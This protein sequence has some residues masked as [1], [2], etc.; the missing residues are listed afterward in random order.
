MADL[1]DAARPPRRVEHDGYLVMFAPDSSLEGLESLHFTVKRTYLELER[2]G[3]IVTQ[4]GR[5]SWVAEQQDARL[6]AAVVR[7]DLVGVF[8][9]RVGHHDLLEQTPEDLPHPVRS[10]LGIEGAPA[11]ELRQQVQ[12]TILFQC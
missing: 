10:E 11:L 12:M 3:V 5:G 2:D 4:Q 1:P 6:H 7:E 8:G 9:A